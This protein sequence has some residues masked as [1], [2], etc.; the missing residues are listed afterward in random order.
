[1]QT[2]AAAVR[3]V[4]AIADA[5]RRHEQRRLLG[6]ER[7]WPKRAV[8]EVSE[9]VK[10][11]LP[12][13]VSAA[14]MEEV[15]WPFRAQ[16]LLALREAGVDL[17][18]FLPRLGEIAVSVRDQVAA[19]SRE[20][21]S[22][23]W[24]RVV[25]E[26]LP[27]G[28][29]REA[30]VSAPGW[31]ELALA[32]DNLEGRGV[33]V[34]EVLAAAYDEALGVAQVVAAGLGA[35]VEPA[36]SQDAQE[37]YGPLTTGLDI[38]RNLNLSN[39]VRAL[40][41]LAISPSDNQRYARW[42]MEAMA[43]RDREANLLLSAR[44]WPLVA[45]R[46]AKMEAEGKPVREHLKHLLTDTSWAAG[47]DGQLGARLVQA[48]AEALRRPVGHAQPVKAVNTAAARATSTTVDPTGPQAAKGATP[49]EPAVTAHRQ[50][51]SAS[52]SGKT[53]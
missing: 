23:R 48:A 30:L 51:M 44:K 36:V 16:E 41:Q 19:K 5:T 28:P 35:S 24:E 2:A 25:R 29:V 49:A 27:A 53:R 20:T 9:D 43:G 13:D 10:R 38:P 14:L 39:R 12:P 3:L 46:M 22:S 4:L 15:D 32:M 18:E 40:Q 37:S 34:R 47:P 31:P 8:G 7:D 26:T 1:M 17:G 45:Y 33:N 42:V 11:L 21:P 52:K 50:A 6:Q